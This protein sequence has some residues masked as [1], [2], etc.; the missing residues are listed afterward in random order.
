MVRQLFRFGVYV[1]RSSFGAG[2]GVDIAY[3]IEFLGWERFRQLRRQRCLFELRL[4]MWGL[5]FRFLFLIF[6]YYF[7]LSDLGQGLRFFD[8]V[9]FWRVFTSFNRFEVQQKVKVCVSRICRLFSSLL[10]LIFGRQRSKEK[11]CWRQRDW[12]VI[13][14]FFWEVFQQFRQNELYFFSFVY[15]VIFYLVGGC[16]FL[17]LFFEILEQEFFRLGF[18]F[19]VFC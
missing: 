16:W 13:S 6:V 12:S 8:G 2:L 4:V 10:L 5:G 1:I 19:R 11:S 15:F 17:G 18:V 14:F 7:F 9:Y 3:W